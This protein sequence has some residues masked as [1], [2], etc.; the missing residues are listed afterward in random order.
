[1]ELAQVVWVGFIA[2]I[3]IKSNNTF[4]L[5]LCFPLL[6]AFGWY[7]YE[8]YHNPPGFVTALVTASLGVY[9]LWTGINNLIR[10]RG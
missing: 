1:M 10:G 4:F 2:Y 7:W 6:L 8:C 5:L 9:C 3:A